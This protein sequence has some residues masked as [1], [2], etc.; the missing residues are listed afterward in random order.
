MN[1]ISERAREREIKSKREWK[2]RRMFMTQI[3]TE[4]LPELDLIVQSLY[5]SPQRSLIIVIMER[6]VGDKR[7]VH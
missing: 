6:L 2:H 7:A 3:P 4:E 5:F 1:F